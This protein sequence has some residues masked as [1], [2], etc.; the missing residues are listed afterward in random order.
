M[1]GRT[2]HEHCKG[3]PPQIKNY[4]FSYS[5]QALADL[6]FIEE[7][8]NVWVPHIKNKVVYCS[9]VEYG[10]KLFI[11]D[12]YWSQMK[13]YLFIY[14]AVNLFTFLFA[15]FLLT[16]SPFLLSTFHFFFHYRLLTF[17][18][19]LFS[20]PSHSALSALSIL[21]GK[22]AA[23]SLN[24]S[25]SVR[26]LMKNSL[27]LQLQ[28]RSQYLDYHFDSLLYFPILS[29]PLHSKPLQTTAPY[30]YLLLYNF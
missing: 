13:S 17:S 2:L 19:P 3:T 5:K 4:T 20:S 23:H 1:G 15:S 29:S 18:S 8:D 11:L 30:R 25:P 22:C 10:V 28:F 14:F 6:G 9:V 16:S 26:Q 24:P 27:Q 21:C 7:V 12:Q